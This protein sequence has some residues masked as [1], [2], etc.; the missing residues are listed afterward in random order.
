MNAVGEWGETALHMAAALGYTTVARA[1]LE[2]GADPNANGPEK[3][4]ATPLIHAARF[5]RGEAA[6]EI[7]NLLLKAGADPQYAIRRDL[8]PLNALAWA[9][10][11]G[12]VGAI[13]PPAAVCSHDNA[14]GEAAVN[15]L[16]EAR[17]ARQGHPVKPER[18][19]FETLKALLDNGVAPTQSTLFEVLFAGYWAAFDAVYAKLQM[20]KDEFDQ[21]A[22]NMITRLVSQG[23]PTNEVT[24]V[25]AT[26][27]FVE[28]YGVD[29]NYGNIPVAIVASGNVE[30]L[31]YA[32]SKG[33]DVKQLDDEKVKAL[34]DEAYQYRQWRHT[35]QDWRER[36][37]ALRQ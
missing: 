8:K 35:P 23:T 16:M 4:G 34:V 29:I 21:F 2:A 18:H 28:E 7:I 13:A 19:A 22:S 5:C 27:R 37:A 20:S 36:I 30:V 9:A 12:N 17:A 10:S 14:L 31:G 15:L 24:I 6:P 25:T 11:S 32:V 1:L 33:L 26:K 3:R